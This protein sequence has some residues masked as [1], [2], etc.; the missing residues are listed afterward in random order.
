MN[1]VSVKLLSR[2]TDLI[3]ITKSFQFQVLG[4]ADRQGRYPIH[5]ELVDVKNVEAEY[6]AKIRMHPSGPFIDIYAICLDGYSHSAECLKGIEHWSQPF[7]RVE[8]EKAKDRLN[9]LR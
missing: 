3:K 5:M 7:V 6:H 1:E 8:A 4:E 9:R 2:F